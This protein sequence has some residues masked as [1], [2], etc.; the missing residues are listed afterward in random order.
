MHNFF[1]PWRNGNSAGSEVTHRPMAAE[2]N[3]CRLPFCLSLK[4]LIHWG[5]LMYICVSKL[6]I[7]GS[8]NGLNKCWN[9]DN[10]N[11][12]TNF[13]EIVSEIYIFSVNKMHLKMSPAKSRPCC[14]CLKVLIYKWKELDPL[15]VKLYFRISAHLVTWGAR[16][17]ATMTHVY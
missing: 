5:Q 6:S 17:S 14:L 16:A 2:I 8:D 11:Q 1:R 13:S 10:L 15:C 3:R 4:V 9:I 7:S 12:R